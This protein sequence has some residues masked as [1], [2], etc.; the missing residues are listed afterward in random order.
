MVIST[1]GV[2]RLTA[3][4]ETVL[5]LGTGRFLRGFVDRFIHQA[6]EAGQEVGRVVAVQST[7]GNRAD[8]LGS[9]PTGYPVLVRGFEEGEI[10]ERV[11]EVAS[12]SRALV[13]SREWNEVLALAKSP[14]LKWIVSNATESGYVLDSADLLSSAPP[15]T[16]PGKLAQVLWTRFSAQGSALTLLP[17]ELIEGNAAKLLGLVRQQAEA[18]KLPPE[19][20]IW[21]SEQCVWLNNLVDCMITSPPVEH[22]LTKANP[23]LIHAEPYTL[24]AIQKPK[25]GEVKLFQHPAIKLVDEL[26]PY[27]FRKV[28]ILNGL[29]SAMVAK[30]MP[31]GFITVQDV[32]KDLTAVRWVRG[33]LWEEIVPTIA[34]RMEGVAE[35]A[36]QTFDRLRNPFLQHKLSDISLNHVDKI[37]VRLQPT[38]DEYVKLF[39]KTPPR[40][41]EVL[42]TKV[43]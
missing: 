6:N 28:R 22:P 38:H 8:A 9:H 1:A 26:G 34:Y 32:L 14:S 42:A 20:L 21:L 25:S 33:L 31:A 11:D 37:R 39:G 41:A 16:L 40:L 18:W 23:L 12:L 4:P 17:C 19:F 24:W 15:K 27:Y 30:F 13:A 35:F 10:V 43:S 5:Q 29:H 7:D 36:D 3:L 2:A